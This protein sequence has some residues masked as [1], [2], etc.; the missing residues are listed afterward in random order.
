MPSEAQTYDTESAMDYVDSLWKRQEN[1][2]LD[3]MT[4]NLDVNFFLMTKSQHGQ[5]RSNYS[6]GSQNRN[7][8][9]RREAAEF[10]L[11][12]DFVARKQVFLKKILD[13]TFIQQSRGTYSEF[14]YTVA[15]SWLEHVLNDNFDNLLK[16]YVFDPLGMAG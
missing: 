3:E 16:K 7:M 12:N 10:I 5:S 11:A 2:T 14:T 6:E 4:L 8:E 9:I 15:V 1:W 13:S